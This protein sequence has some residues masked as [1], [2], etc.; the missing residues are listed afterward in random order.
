MTGELGQKT[1]NIKFHFDKIGILITTSTFFYKGQNIKNQSGSL[2]QTSKNL[3]YP[4]NH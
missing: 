1:Q 2:H 4:L 3:S